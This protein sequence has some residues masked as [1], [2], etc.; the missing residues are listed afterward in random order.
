MAAKEEKKPLLDFLPINPTAKRY[1]SIS[2]SK[3]AIV[4]EPRIPLD[5]T[6]PSVL[7]LRPRSD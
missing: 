7:A 3:Y 2:I 5:A 6:P 4:K 1:G